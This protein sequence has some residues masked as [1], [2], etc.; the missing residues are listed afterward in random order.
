MKVKYILKLIKYHI[1]LTLY[2]NAKHQAI[3]FGGTKSCMIITRLKKPIRP[4]K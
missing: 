4:V 1:K 3:L 2:N